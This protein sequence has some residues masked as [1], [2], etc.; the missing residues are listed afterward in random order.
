MSVECSECESD[1]RAG[2]DPDCSRSPQSELKLLRK[3]YE[4]MWSALQA[5]TATGV[6]VRGELRTEIARLRAA[7]L[8]I[9]QW[10]CLNLPVAHIKCVRDASDFPWLKRLVDDALAHI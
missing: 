8:K 6:Q 2:H 5:E 7:L 10:D 4:R 9:Q 1:A 3:D